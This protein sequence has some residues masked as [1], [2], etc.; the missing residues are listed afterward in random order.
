MQ[1]AENLKEMLK[2]YAD[3]EPDVEID[4]ITPHEEYIKQFLEMYKK[5]L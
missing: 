3:S 5:K 4:V 2:A 1:S